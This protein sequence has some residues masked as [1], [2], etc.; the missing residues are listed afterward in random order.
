MTSLKDHSGRNPVAL[1]TGAG[2]GIGRASAIA[3]SNAG[4]DCVL[5]SRTKSDLEEVRS[6][7]KTDSIAIVCDVS[8]SSE[9]NRAVEET[10]SRFGRLDAVV[11]NAGV[12]PLLPIETMSDELWHSV[13][14]TNLSSTFYFTRA[15]WPTMV[16]QKSGVIVNISSEAARDPFTGFAA[17][18]AAKAGVNLFTLATAQEGA[19]HNIRVHAVGPAATETTMFRKLMSEDQF[20]RDNTLDPMA[21]AAVVV[22]CVCGSLAHASGEVIYLHKTV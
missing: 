16:K 14:D 13:I 10:L 20:S 9:V 22:Q 5:V 19:A 15:A 11:N 18:A 7:L 1:I 21:V 4:Y 17:Y 2:R 6:Q 8:Q 3:L 12:A